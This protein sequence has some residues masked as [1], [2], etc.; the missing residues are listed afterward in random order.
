M[1]S[2]DLV[3]VVIE[4]VAPILLSASPSTAVSISV[5]ASP[6][7]V[8][9]KLYNDSAACMVL[10]LLLFSS[11]SSI[12]EGTVSLESAPFRAWNVIV[13]GVDADG[14]ESLSIPGMIKNS[15]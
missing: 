2:W 6:C 14:D 10:S 13:I 1:P 9:D 11:E 5:L 12:G 3:L 4:G 8:M 7:V 15:F